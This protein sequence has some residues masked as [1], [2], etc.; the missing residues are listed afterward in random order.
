MMSS[1][2][3]DFNNSIFDGLPIVPMV[4][5]ENFFAILFA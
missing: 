3:S 1:Y 4:Y 2:P 5:A